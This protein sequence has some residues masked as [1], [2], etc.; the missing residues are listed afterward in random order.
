MVAPL[1]STTGV[2]TLSSMSVT[3]R[4]ESV[5][6][7]RRTRT[8]T[9]VATFGHVLGGACGILRFLLLNHR[10][11]LSFPSFG[12]LQAILKVTHAGEILIEP[13]AIRGPYTALQDH[14]PVRTRRQG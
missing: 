5:S 4:V 8:R 12:G 9:L 13:L 1:I 14:G 7:A 10:L 2:L 3:A 6:N 11:G